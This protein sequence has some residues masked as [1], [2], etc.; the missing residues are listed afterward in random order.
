[1]Q[2]SIRC[3]RTRSPASPVVAAIVAAVAVVVVSK[4]RL[5]QPSSSDG[6]CFYKMKF[7][8]PLA[9]ILL[10]LMQRVFTFDIY[11]IE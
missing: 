5:V 6:G 7:K 9:R 8:E 10:P 3:T 4:Y 11:L 1:M 2:L